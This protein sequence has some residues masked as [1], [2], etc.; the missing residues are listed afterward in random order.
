[1]VYIN[2]LAKPS[3]QAL[4]EQP[5]LLMDKV[6]EFLAG[7]CQV[8][9]VL[10]DSG[11]GKS[12]FN[13]Y[14]E[15]QLWQD[16]KAGDCI[17]L[18]INLPTLDRP[19]KE[20]VVEQLRISDF[21]EEV[22]RELK[23]HRQLL[24]ICDGYD[25][26]QLTTNLHTTNLFNR[27]GQWNVKLL[28]TCRTQYLGP[29]YRDRFVPRDEGQYQGAADNLFQEVVISPFSEDQIELYIEKYVPLEPRTWVKKDY[30]NKSTTIPHL[31]ELARNPFLLTL[32]LEA[33]PIVVEGKPD[34]S[35]LRITSVELYDTFVEHWLSVNKR[36]L[37]DQKLS[38]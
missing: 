37:Q 15:Y 10:G 24:L 25:E 19:D 22:I 26:S 33:L 34:I 29:D 2:P 31:M 8:M 11:A 36:R 6:K 35:K 3:L 32:A 12:T 18:F 17:P 20:L 5:F 27:S 4:D 21:P 38:E 9:L 13:R 14:L 1:M 30:M 7:D 23:R 16:Y 28:V